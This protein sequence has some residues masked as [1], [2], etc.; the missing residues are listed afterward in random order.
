MIYP[1]ID[2]DKFPDYKII[3]EITWNKLTSYSYK[4]STE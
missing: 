3:Q 2:T 1:E 4:V